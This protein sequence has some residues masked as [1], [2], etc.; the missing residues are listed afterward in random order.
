VLVL[1]AW[2]IRRELQAARAG[3]MAVRPDARQALMLPGV[4]GASSQEL[5]E[6]D[7]LPSNE[8]PALLLRLLVQALRQSGRLRNDR[9]LT[10]RELAARS[11]FDD[12]QQ[13]GSFARLSLLAERLLYGAI[14]PAAA[15]GAQ[16]QIEQALADGRQLYAQL[17]A[18][19]AAAQ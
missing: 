13:H 19:R 14:T 1:A 15:A 8:Q 12:Q 3:T 16:P 9:S 10:H 5:A 2:I 7:Q 11:A 4:A 6:L 17:I 18:A